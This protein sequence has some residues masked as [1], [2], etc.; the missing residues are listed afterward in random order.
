MNV[1]TTYADKSFLRVTLA[2]ESFRNAGA[3]YCRAFPLRLE[4]NNA[5]YSVATFLEEPD[6]TMLR[7]NG[8]DPNGAFYKMYNSLESASGNQKT[9]RLNEDNSD[10]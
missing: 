3:P 9:T 8:L 6:E 4:Q 7:R 10:L 2:W 5:F 1:N